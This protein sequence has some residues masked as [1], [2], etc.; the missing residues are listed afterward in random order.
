[1][2]QWV[3]YLLLKPKSLGSIPSTHMCIVPVLKR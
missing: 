1:M 3:E 2:A